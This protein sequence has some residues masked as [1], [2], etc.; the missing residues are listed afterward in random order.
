MSEGTVVELRGRRG[1][2][3]EL[4]QQTPSEHAPA[5]DAPPQHGPLTP[6]PHLHEPH[7][8]P[9]QSPHQSP[10]QP[11]RPPPQLQDLQPPARALVGLSALVWFYSRWLRRHLVQDLLAA[12]GVATAVALVFA[13]IIA[14]SSLSNATRQAVR[15]VVGPA[16]LQLHARSAQGI[17]AALLTEARRLPGVQAT[18][19]LLESTAR[20]RAEDGREA[21]VDLAGAGT[22]LVFLDGLIHTIPATTLSDSGIGLSARTAEELGL[23]A[24]AARSGR[25]L[26]LYLRGRAIS[27]PISAVLGQEAFRALAHTS[28]AVMQLAQLQRLARL[29]HRLSRVLVQVKRGQRSR[30]D[31]ELRTLAQ[32]RIEVA[33]ASQDIG[34]LQQALQP[35]EQASALFAAVSALLGVLLATAALLL[36]A[37]DRRRAIADMRII[38]IRRTV[39]VQ[40][41]GFQSLVLATLACVVGVACG[42]VLSLTLLAQ[43]PR[44]LSEAFTLG[45]QS[46]PDLLAL[47]AALATGLASCAIAS[48]LPLLDLR[49]R[50]ALRSV[51]QKPGVPGN[52][53]QQGTRRALQAGAMLLLLAAAAIALASPAQTLIACVLIAL[54]TVCAVP[55]ALDL[56]TAACSRLSAWQERLTALPVAISS[57][58]ATSLRSFALA[59][60][61]ALALFGCISLGGARGDLASGIARFARSYAADAS[62]WVGN[63]GDDQAVLQL[64]A[65]DLRA[66]TAALAGVAGT[67]RFYGGF[68]IIDGRRAWVIA[69]PPHSAAHL[70]ASQLSQGSPAAAERAIAA[71]ASVIVSKQI[72]AAQH[73]QVGGML[74]IPTPTGP[75]RLRIAALSTNLAW[76]PGTIILGSSE[77]RRLW[78]GAQPT[79]LAISVRHGASPSALAA[80]IRRLLPAG[81]GLTVRTSAQ[82]R[83]SI[84]ALTGEGLSQLQEISNLLLAAAILAMA[85]ALASAAWQRRSALAGLRLCG[86]PVPRLRRILLAEAG[87]LLGAGCV[88]GAL[89]GIAGQ[90]IIDRYLELHTGFPVA[91]IATDARALLIFALVLGVVLLAALSPILIASKVSP[92]FA[93][94]E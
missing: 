14:S 52:A 75:A 13:T 50:N 61:G 6:Q 23:T 57:L 70:L 90:A 43:S 64:S 12:L 65:H 27:L 78:P 24:S 1:S 35:S 20:L 29:P 74:T 51:Y 19:S 81:S 36:S 59:S 54:G 76:S 56:V 10:D 62:I 85:A 48:A 73:A 40:M 32:G 21:T 18:G 63:R 8:A 42:F 45:S 17:S 33:S 71:G 67:S 82:L 28:V 46:T 86:V 66:R 68:D 80:R 4:P 31:A 38:G 53:L 39:I 69:R 79:A 72:A 94:A 7:R 91:P 87:M 84:D 47:S 55:P 88:T 34:L 77:Y 5:Q 58:Q 83:A 93:L 60:T 41:F 11:H 26:T 37:A 44:Y 30:V 15:T 22:S 92:T 9:H 89:T 2:L 25:R 3:P 49:D 16:S